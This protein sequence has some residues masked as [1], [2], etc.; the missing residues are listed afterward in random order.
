[1][2]VT[3]LPA[4]PKTLRRRTTE[5]KITKEERLLIVKDYME[6]D[7]T[8]AEIGEKFK[9][10]AKNVEMIVSRHWKSLTNVRE[11]KNLVNGQSSK[12][13]HKNSNYMVLKSIGSVPMINKDFLS[14]LSEPDDHLLTDH[15]LQYCY[16]FAVTGDNYQS[17]N[18]SG[19][20]I[21]LTGS[22]GDKK[23]H[24]FQLACRL[25]GHFLRNKKNVAEYIIKLKEEQFLPDVIDKAFVQ[26]ELLEQLAQLKESNDD[27]ANRA[28]I[29][30]TIEN[31]GRT[32]GAFSDVIK[33]EEV[34]PAKALDYLESLASA[35]ATQLLGNTQILE[36]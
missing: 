13:I 6:T 10:T 21:G 17:I 16:N 32:V 5:S 36:E 18:N 7:L 27:G 20:T 34:D 33:V 30:K 24:E 14:L 22:A 19:L 9:T 3:K 12:N 15:E 2:K 1:M 23:R 25:R 26:K 35:D 28:Q 31:I 29:N 8:N 4:A 11:T